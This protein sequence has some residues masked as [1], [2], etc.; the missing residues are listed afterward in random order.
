[1]V[2]LASRDVRRPVPL[3]EIAAGEGI[4]APFLERILARLRDSG[5]VQ[6]TRGVSGGYQLT[7]PAAAIAVGEVVTALEGP[8]A[9]VGC[10]PDDGACERAESCASRMVW[11]RLDDAITGALNGITLQDLTRE[12]VSQ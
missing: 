12:A 7:R 8:L 11:R 4:P 5:L 6:A 3:P 10:L 2:Y 1:M 9:L